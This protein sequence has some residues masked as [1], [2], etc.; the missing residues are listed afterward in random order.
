MEEVTFMEKVKKTAFKG[1]QF[2]QMPYM[3]PNFYAFY[4]SLAILIKVMF[5]NKNQH[6]HKKIQGR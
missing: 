4:W 1:G 2:K 5:V 6:S 3:I